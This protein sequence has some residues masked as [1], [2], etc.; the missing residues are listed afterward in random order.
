MVQVS[1]WGNPATAGADDN[2]D[3]SELW[4]ALRRR[5]KLVG[6]TAAAVLTL[7]AGITVSQRLFRP[8]YEGGFQL[9]ISDPISD[10]NRGSGGQEAPGG[11]MYAELARN[12]TSADIPTLIEL[13]RSPAMLAP[14]AS[15]FDLG[16]AALANRI[17]I[18]TGGTRQA[19]AE[20]V[21]KV[22][23]RQTPARGPQQHLPAGRPQPAAAAP[24][25]RHSLPQPA[26]PGP[27]SQNRRA[28]G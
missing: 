22:S 1:D 5:R 16:A 7:T 15:R 6:I 26:G 17:S 27:R 8:V 2:L 18:A 4:R 14:I 21:I 3:L 24:S 12:T 25:R 9:L 11:T 28:P 10:E 20:G 19:S 13:L 23:L